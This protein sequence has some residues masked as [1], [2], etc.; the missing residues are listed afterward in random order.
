V[1]IEMAESQYSARRN[2]RFWPEAAIGWEIDVGPLRA[3]PVVPRG[4]RSLTK[5][6]NRAR[7][8]QSSFSAPA[9]SF[10]KLNGAGFGK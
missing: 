8:Q 3:H 7:P 5:P 6:A 1:K 10:E 9:T 4:W 2:Y